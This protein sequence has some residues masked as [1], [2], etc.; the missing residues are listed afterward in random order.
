[1]DPH[2]YCQERAAAYLLSDADVIILLLSTVPALCYERSEDEMRL[3]RDYENV[4]K[5]P[6]HTVPN[7]VSECAYE[8]CVAFRHIRCASSVNAL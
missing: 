2:C 1:M 7:H 3:V 6:T 4:S 5:K 8:R